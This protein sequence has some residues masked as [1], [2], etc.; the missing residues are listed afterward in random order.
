YAGFASHCDYGPYAGYIAG[1]STTSPT[2]TTL[3]STEAGSGSGMAGIWQSG[4]GLVSDGSGRIIFATGNGVSPAPG[5]GT[6]PPGNLG[7][8]VVRL[9]VNSD[10]SLVS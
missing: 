1:F 3:W 6:S 2:Q 5:P 9:Q 8:S 4:G 7:E 10:R